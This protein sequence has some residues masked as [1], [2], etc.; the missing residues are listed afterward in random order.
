MFINSIQKS[1]LIVKIRPNLYQMP[2]G[3]LVGFGQREAENG[4]SW[5]Y[6][7]SEPECIHVEA[8]A[9]AWLGGMSVEAQSILF[10][11]EADD[12]GLQEPTL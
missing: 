8:I 5:C 3:Q 9:E 4:I 7:C 10:N 2:H 12:Y 11:R 6:N 1:N